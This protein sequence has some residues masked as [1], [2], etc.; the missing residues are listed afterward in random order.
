MNAHYVH[1]YPL[2]TGEDLSAQVRNGA[3]PLIEAGVI[4]PDQFQTWLD[5]LN[6]IFD[7]YDGELVGERW[8][9]P[10]DLVGAN[11]NQYYRELAA[12]IQAMIAKIMEQ[13]MA[14]V[15]QGFDPITLGFIILMGSLIAGGL[16]YSSY[17]FG[18][19]LSGAVQ[20]AARIDSV[21][22][23]EFGS[24]PDNPNCPDWYE[25]PEK[26]GLIVIIIWLQSLCAAT[27]DV[28]GTNFSSVLQGI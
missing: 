28:Y 10:E 3:Q 14:A 22:D 13:A 8:V 4:N 11:A 25:E 21:C 7:S 23:P 12:R 27:D 17:R 18:Q 5:R 26:N 9:P 20:D 2:I 6:E 16:G 15:R 19:K 1:P 24:D